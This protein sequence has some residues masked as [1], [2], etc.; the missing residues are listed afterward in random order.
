MNI[1]DLRVLLSTYKIIDEGTE[2]TLHCFT[3]SQFM[4]L[5]QNFGIKYNFTLEVNSSV[6]FL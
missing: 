6:F 3:R 5:L 2:C 4:S 1:N